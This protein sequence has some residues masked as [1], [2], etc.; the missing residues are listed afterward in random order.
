MTIMLCRLLQA[1]APPA[2]ASKAA[3]EAAPAPAADT[4]NQPDKKPDTQDKVN[5][6]VQSSDCLRTVHQ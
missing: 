3:A 6:G 5:L 4:D 2:D 1:Q